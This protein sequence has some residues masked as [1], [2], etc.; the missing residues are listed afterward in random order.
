MKYHVLASRMI[1]TV[2]PC[3]RASLCF[4]HA[5]QFAGD[6]MAL[7]IIPFERAEVIDHRQ[8]LSGNWV[9]QPEFPAAGIGEQILVPHLSDGSP[10]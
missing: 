8:D 6:S 2:R 7:S 10:C 5:F 1:F 3:N 9:N 4:H